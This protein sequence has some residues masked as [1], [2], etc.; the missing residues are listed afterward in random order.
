MA[1]D[2]RDARAHTEEIVVLNSRCKLSALQGTLRSLAELVICEANVGEEIVRQM[3]D[4]VD[5]VAKQPHVGAVK[6]F[7]VKIMTQ[8]KRR[9]AVW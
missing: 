1:V 3:M 7:A 2:D 4:A 5:L 9:C 8:K 6:D